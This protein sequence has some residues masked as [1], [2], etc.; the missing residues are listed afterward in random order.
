MVLITDGH[1]A[2]NQVDKGSPLPL[3]FDKWTRNTY[4]NLNFLTRV[5]HYLMG[6]N[7]RLAMQSKSYTVAYLDPTKV[8]K[9]SQSWIIILVLGSLCWFGGLYW[10]ISQLRKRR[11]GVH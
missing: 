11:L 2:E 4:D 3:G 1:L 8:Q 5:T 7:E 9:N 6:Q 10:G